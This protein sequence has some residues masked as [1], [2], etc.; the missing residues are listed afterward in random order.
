MRPQDIAILLKIIAIR[1]HPW[2]LKDLAS[3][4]HISASEVSESLNRSY[5][6]GLVDYNKK[7]VSRQSLLEFLQHG[8]QY[9]FPQQPGGMANGIPTAHGHTYMKQFFESDVTYVWPDIHGKSRGLVIEP[10]YPKQTEAVKEDETLYKLLALVD[11]IRV[12]RRREIN[13]AVNEL[14]KIILHEPSSQLVA[15]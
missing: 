12:G 3:M 11:V 5:L 2:Q 14:S 6:A 15:H 8:L 4:L 10:L 13:I 1:Q 7:K 9:V